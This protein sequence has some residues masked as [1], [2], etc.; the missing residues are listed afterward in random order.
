MIFIFQERGKLFAKSFLG[1]ISSQASQIPF[2]LGKP[3][4]GIFSLVLKN[5]SQIINKPRLDLNVLTISCFF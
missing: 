4:L 2:R 3:N 5:V 1:V